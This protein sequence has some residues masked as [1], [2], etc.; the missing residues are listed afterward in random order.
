MQYSKRICISTFVIR[1]GQ[2]GDNTGIWKRHGRQ[3]SL[4]TQAEKGMKGM[5]QSNLTTTKKKKPKISTSRMAQMFH[6][7]ELS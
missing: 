3:V 4:P 6:S 2:A 1:F 7:C 5:A